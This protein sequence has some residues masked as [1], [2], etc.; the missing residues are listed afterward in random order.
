MT[1]RCT[2]ALPNAM[3][4]SVRNSIAATSPTMLNDHEPNAFYIFFSAFRMHKMC[5]CGWPSAPEIF[6]EDQFVASFGF[7]FIF[8]WF[9]FDP[10]N[11]LINFFT[12]NIS[13]PAL[14]WVVWA[15]NPLIF[16]D[17]RPFSGPHGTYYTVQGSFLG[18]S[19][20]NLLLSCFSLGKKI[21]HKISCLARKEQLDLW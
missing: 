3:L 2:V 7:H 20:A 11:C 16:R 10:C 6:L 18:C 4:Q 8:I 9:L 17:L 19:S 13:I 1:T 15:I 21:T 14:P 5:Q 12:A